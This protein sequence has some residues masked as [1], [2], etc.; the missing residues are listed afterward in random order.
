LARDF[1]ALCCCR[2]G[3]RSC[4]AGRELSEPSLRLA[5]SGGVREKSE[6]A[7]IPSN[8][9]LRAQAERSSNLSFID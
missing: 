7:R 2:S 5:E 6:A 4:T 8:G 9:I 3:A 1:L